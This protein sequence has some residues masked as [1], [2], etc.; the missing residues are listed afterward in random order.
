[1]YFCLGFAAG[2]GDLPC[3]QSRFNGFIGER[4]LDHVYG[5]LEKRPKAV[6]VLSRLLGVVNG[7]ELSVMSIRLNTIKM[8]DAVEAYTP[9]AWAI[10]QWGDRIALGSNFN[11]YTRSNGGLRSQPEI[12]IFK[13][14]YNSG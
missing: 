11:S 6:L 2:L 4:S 13:M 14:K 8:M 5:F 9:K 7:R 10:Y 3:I 1:M 12:T